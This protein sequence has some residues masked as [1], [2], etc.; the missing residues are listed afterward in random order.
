M[1]FIGERINGGF[2]DIVKA[3]KEKNSDIIKKWA[4]RQT[5][6]RAN[7]IDVNIG[8]VSNK[9]EDYIWMIETVQE[10]VPTPISIDTNKLE[11]VKEAL[12]LCQKAP[13]I[14]STTAHDEKL[15]QL[16]GLAVEHEVSLIGV[17]MDEKGSPQDVNRRVELGAKIFTYAVE[18]GLPPERLFLDP[19]IMPLKFLQ[20]QATN[21]LEAISQFKLLSDPP[22]HVAVGL[23]NISSQTMESK[24]I[25]RTFLV[26][27]IEAGLDAVICDVTDTELVNATIT[28][29]L[30]KGK[31]IYSDS[32]LKAYQ[33][34]KKPG[35]SD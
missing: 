21:V 4:I 18:R 11:F 12:K 25:N 8:A 22:P 15:D 24:L 14:N 27:A 9:V 5:Q 23:S 10:T 16:V 13:L 32:F 33:V 20:P 29:E 6:A 2:K 26:M 34:A 1:I 30:I 35:V 3:V 31:H 28:A 17:C 19:V 7:Y